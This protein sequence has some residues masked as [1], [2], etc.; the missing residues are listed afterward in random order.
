MYADFEELQQLHRLQ[1]LPLLKRGLVTSQHNYIPPALSP[2]LPVYNIHIHI[3]ISVL[4]WL[5]N[6]SR[7]NDQSISHDFFI[8]THD[9]LGEHQNYL[10]HHR[11]VQNLRICLQYGH[12][13]K[14]VTLAAHTLFYRA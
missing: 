12:I 4:S 5:P 8:Y 9:H 13:N 6:F 11:E 1:Q 3:Y 10:V 2:C 14:S 7:A